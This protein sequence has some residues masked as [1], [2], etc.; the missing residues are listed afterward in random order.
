MSGDALAMNE[1]TRILVGA[2]GD[3]GWEGRG[4]FFAAVAEAMRR[5]PIDGERE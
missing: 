4:Y 5:I 2:N 3:N 1:V